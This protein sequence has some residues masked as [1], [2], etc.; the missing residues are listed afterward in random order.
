MQ[1]KTV[2]KIC[3]ELDSLYIKLKLVGLKSHTSLHSMVIMKIAC[4]R[5][6]CSFMFV[7]LKLKNYNF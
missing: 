1:N 5:E 3:L 7:A 6:L 4:D 2:Q